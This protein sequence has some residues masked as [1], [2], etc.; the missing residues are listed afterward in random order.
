MPK[1][2]RQNVVLDADTVVCDVG[3]RVQGQWRGDRNEGWFKGVIKEKKQDSGGKWMYRVKY[4]DND[5]E[6]L[7]EKYVRVYNGSD[8][9]A[10]VVPKAAAERKSPSKEKAQS[11]DDD[12]ML[13]EDGGSDEDEDKIQQSDD[14][15]DDDDDDSGMDA[16]SD[17]QP[18]PP[19]VRAKPASQVEVKSEVKSEKEPLPDGFHDGYVVVTH[20]ELMAY[21]S[22]EAGSGATF[23]QTAARLNGNRNKMQ[24]DAELGT[25]SAIDAFHESCLMHKM[26]WELDLLRT[27]YDQPRREKF[28]NRMNEDATTIHPHLVHEG[29]VFPFYDARS[30]HTS[31]NKHKVTSTLR[32]PL[33]T[34][35]FPGE[36]EALDLLIGGRPSRGWHH[37]RV[38]SQG[39]TARV[40]LKGK[41]CGLTCFS[42]GQR[43]SKHREHVR[44]RLFRPLHLPQEDRQV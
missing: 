15:D 16:F 25:R 27:Y 29:D 4:D 43:N 28:F 36:L 8:N 6:W 31:G 35:L 17:R 32:L 9:K 33:L 30:I 41:W 13:N 1:R 2:T 14:D 18:L 20:N 24:D 44:R 22:I 19:K 34:C 3:V 23:Q 11:D 39:V 42:S 21:P 38:H 7:K 10:K 5:S 40:C 37:C 12:N 26:L